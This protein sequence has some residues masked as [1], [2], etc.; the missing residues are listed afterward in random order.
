MTNREHSI[1]QIKELIKKAKQGKEWKNAL[2]LTELLHEADERDSEK[3]N[4]W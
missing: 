1:E 3:R 2:R 4:N